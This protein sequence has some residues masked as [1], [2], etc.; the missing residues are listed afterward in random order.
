MSIKELFRNEE[1]TNIASDLSTSDINSELD[2]SNEKYI[3]IYESHKNRV[4]PHTD[5]SDPEAFA[6]YGSAEKYYYDSI[7]RIYN[8]YPYDGSAFEKT[9]WRLSSSYL[10]LHLIDNEYPKTNG[11]ISLATE[12]WGDQ[13]DSVSNYGATSTSSYEY[14]EVANPINKDNKVDVDNGVGFNLN[15]DPI[16]GNTVEFWLKKDGLVSSGKTEREVIFDLWNGASTLNAQYARFRV[17]LDTTVDEADSPFLVTYMSGA[18]GFNS[19]PIGDT[20]SAAKM[21]NGWN[22]LALSFM[23][24]SASSQIKFYVNGELEHTIS[25]SDTLSAVVNTGSVMLLG[26]LVAAP[27]GSAYLDYSDG[28]MKGW[29]KLSGSLDEF[30]FWKRCRNSR[31]ISRNWFTH[32]EGGSNE[33]GNL[34]SL[35][36]Y[37][38]FNEGVTENS[39]I[40]SKI[41][42]YSGKVSNGNWVGYPGPPA[43]STNSAIVEHGA[44]ELEIKDPIIYQEHPSIVKLAEEKRKIGV[45]YDDR[46]NSTIIDSLPSWIIDNDDEGAG[47]LKNITQVI[48]SYFD[49]LQI[50]VREIPR[51]LDASYVSGSSKGEG[52]YKPLPFSDR[53]LEAK[54]FPAPDIFIDAE[55]LDFFKSRGEELVY[56]DNLHDIKNLIYNNIYNN[57]IYIYKSKGT[58]KSFRNLLHCY[59]IDD[60]LIKVNVYSDNETYSLKDT[61]RNSIEK[62]KYVDFFNRDHLDACVI[63]YTSSTIPDAYSYVSNARDIAPLNL[64]SIEKDRFSRKSVTAEIE[65][66]FPKLL[67]QSS[68][69][70]FQVPITS[71]I[72][73]AHA[74]ANSADS[75]PIDYTW[76]T[77]DSGSFQVFAVR[78]NIDSPN[79]RFMLTSSNSTLFTELTSSVFADVYSDQRWHFAVRVKQNK[80]KEG[81]VGRS[82]YL[83][84]SPTDY[85]I[86]FYGVRPIIDNTSESFLV[87]GS[88]TK[89]QGEAFLSSNKRFF[90][91]AHRENF[92]GTV[93]QQAAPRVSSF[94]YWLDYLEDNTLNKHA[95]SPLNYGTDNPI[96]NAYFYEYG[97]RD[98]GAVSPYG[99]SWDRTYAI[100][101]SAVPKS[102][103][104]A[105]NWS[106]DELTGSYSVAEDPFINFEVTDQS[107]GSFPN[108][109]PAGMANY[110][111][112]TLNNH[113]P[114]AGFGFPAN[115]KESIRVQHLQTAKKTLLENISNHDSIEVVD[116]IESDLFSIDER[117]IKYFISLEKSMY[118]NISEEIINMFS[119]M[120]AF[121]NIIGEPVERYRHSY[122]KLEK[123][124][125]IFFEKVHSDIDLD[126]FIDFYKWFDISISKMIAELIP[127]SARASDK[128]YNIVESHI[129]ERNK[130]QTKI[131]TLDYRGNELETTALPSGIIDRTS[132]LEERISRLNREISGYPNSQPTRPSSPQREV[133]NPIW[134]RWYAERN[135][136]S[137][138]AGV[139]LAENREALLKVIKGNRE[140]SRESLVRTTFNIDRQ[141]KVGSNFYSNKNYNFHKGLTTVDKIGIV[142]K[143]SIQRLSD[144]EFYQDLLSKEKMNFNLDTPSGGVSGDTGAPFN[145]FSSSV[146]T[147]YVESSG[148]RALKEDVIVTNHHHDQYNQELSI[149]SP[150]TKAHV[151]GMTHREISINRGADNIDNRPEAWRLNIG[152]N[153]LEIS[154]SLL[155]D[156]KPHLPRSYFY[157]DGVARRPLNIANIKYSTGSYILGNYSNE[158]EIVQTSNRTLNNQWFVKSGSIAGTIKNYSIDSLRAIETSPSLYVGGLSEYKKPERGKTKHVIVERF[159]APG[160]PETMGD[161]NGGHGL[162]V[163][164]AEYSPYNMM[165]Y[166]N[167]NV[168]DFLDRVSR[169][170]TGPA[171]FSAFTGDTGSW[172]SDNPSASYYKINNNP[173]TKIIYDAGGYST[174]AVYDNMFLQTPIPAQDYGY[175]WITASITGSKDVYGHATNPD[176][177]IFYTASGLMYS[178][179]N[180]NI[181]SDS[182]L[183][184]T[185]SSGNS[186]NTFLNNIN[187]VGG[188]TPWKEISGRYHPVRRYQVKNNIFSV[189]R[190]EKIN[191]SDG[192]ASLLEIRYGY[193]EPPLTN[194]YKYLSHEFINSEDPNF[195]IVVDHSYANNKSRF[196]N[197]GLTL[198]LYGEGEDSSEQI[199]D[200]LVSDYTSVN[201]GKDTG[202]KFKN[203][204]YRET[205][206]PKEKNT[207]L[208]KSRTR[209]AFSYNNIWVSGS[210]NGGYYDPQD[211]SYNAFFTETELESFFVNG[212]NSEDAPEYLPWF[213]AHGAFGAHGS[214]RLALWPLA[215]R[216]D[217]LTD[218]PPIS[219][220]AQLPY[221]DAEDHYTGSDN[222]L[223]LEDSGELQSLRVTFSGRSLGQVGGTGFSVSPIYQRRVMLGGFDLTGTCNSGTDKEFMGGDMIWETPVQSGYDPYYPSYELYSETM[224]AQGKDYTVVPEYRFTPLLQSYRPMVEYGDSGWGAKDHELYSEFLT[225]T[226]DNSNLYKSISHAYTITGSESKDSRDRDFISEYLHTDFLKYFDVIN[227]QHDRTVGANSR[228]TS[229][230]YEA[231]TVRLTC[232]AFKRFLPYKGF[233]PAERALEISKIFWNTHKYLISGSTEWSS[234]DIGTTLANARPLAQALFSPGILFNTIKSGI[235]VDYP[236]YTSSLNYGAVH[237]RS[238]DERYG[239]LYI[240]SPDTPHSHHQRVFDLLTSSFDTRV[241]FEAIMDP[242]EYI[243]HKIYDQEVHPLSLVDGNGDFYFN[244]TVS[245]SPLY[246]MAINN[247]LAETMNL[248]LRNQGPSKIIS[249]KVRTVSVDT[250][251]YERYSMDVNLIQ[252]QDFT[253]YNRGSAFG[254]ATARKHQCNDPSLSGY[255]SLNLGLQRT[256]SCYSP[257]TPPYFDSFAGKSES[258]VAI[259]NEPR[260]AIARVVFP[261]EGVTLEDRAYT[262]PEI[263]RSSSISYIRPNEGESYSANSAN[264]SSGGVYASRNYYNQS[265][266]GFADAMQISSS[267]NLTDFITFN[268]TT[269]DEEGGIIN[270]SEQGSEEKPITQWIISPKFECP[271]LNFENSAYTMPTYGHASDYGFVSKGMWHQQGEIPS[272]NSGIFLTITDSNLSEISWPYRAGQALSSVNDAFSQQWAPSQTEKTGSLAKLLDFKSPDTNTNKVKIGEVLS[273]KEFK[274]VYEAVVAIPFVLDSSDNK[275]FFKIDKNQV[276]AIKNGQSYDRGA[277]EEKSYK[278][279]AKIVNCLNKYVFPPQFDFVRTEDIDPFAMF[280]FEFDYKFSGEDLSNM[281][282]NVLPPSSD[283]TFGP[284]VQPNEYEDTVSESVVA[285]PVLYDMF[286]NYSDTEGGDRLRWFV[287]KV[288]QKALVN[289]NDLIRASRLDKRLMDNI[290]KNT[291]NDKTITS[292][293]VSR[294]N[295]MV[296]ATLF[297]PKINESLDVSNSLKGYSYNWPYDYFSFVELIKINAE[298]TYGVEDSGTSNLGYEN[299]RD[300]MPSNA[301]TP[302]TAGVV[303]RPPDPL[304]NR[305]EVANSVLKGDQGVLV[306]DQSKFNF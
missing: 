140:I 167:R 88:L 207:F 108:L 117:P 3:E 36:V 239:P 241:P 89:D 210:L 212:R 248:F 72:F 54:G 273:N 158:S 196:S 264:D 246:K 289:Y 121:N 229:G 301:S 100:T 279:T 137:F 284:G 86:S 111:G 14:I 13:V 252:T 153:Q 31:E 168:R 201:P 67:E 235:A 71:S 30:R 282:Q 150:F 109:A 52:Y 152:A 27:E 40:D 84:A 49:S 107:S 144:V 125:Q 60:E 56:K 127:V 174:G 287:F 185:S 10:D 104:L 145:L 123:L 217:F 288:K 130:Y 225:N 306:P 230:E 129:L 263:I 286:Y 169:Q 151:G 124:R 78:N 103:T 37:F 83:P 105:I 131:P 12:G 17:E 76:S 290:L 79:V 204:I 115:T 200:K 57:L 118:Q 93:L 33:S 4:L 58:E 234:G 183:F 59:G 251:S 203:L 68:K 250:D 300:N 34:T 254:P 219:G 258:G 187:G 114:A 146:S 29:A 133:Q 298:V 194:K 90:V 269:F 299:L 53:K 177:I 70:Y 80:E 243:Q 128:I 155:I 8:T 51:L 281:W 191:L 216:S 110:I 157:R 99:E 189:T 227:D 195:S 75:D 64:T 97:D 116:T 45:E 159:S 199:Y 119:S 182:N 176:Q 247:F 15:I 272:E 218:E 43:R 184:T 5:L 255:V 11:Y 135:N 39:A 94:R 237:S 205:V 283:K 197:K 215:C 44:A 302:R 136:P 226:P 186:L 238:C 172:Y 236:V 77:A 120:E 222:N 291:K 154:S 274:E 1:A 277:D 26:S 81:N 91:G 19:T 122:K 63:Q 198:K 32:V 7:K 18:E 55:I 188:Y 223:N 193:H 249:K 62:K 126:R 296:E 23:S 271:A 267:V 82:A 260:P 69:K 163:F 256:G 179:L 138:G 161:A 261:K 233:Y 65:A 46:N 21:L 178:R 276:N 134:W 220:S 73:G 166:R 132:L 266:P 74:T 165:N 48:A 139:N 293:D 171:G 242:I 102:R 50:Q 244:Q 175:S 253:L 270:T 294:I 20:F 9:T 257:F 303:E 285:H 143:D 106:F 35:G 148:L 85:K 180:T 259:D 232:K 149:Q 305:T 41:L 66:F 164:A 162:D 113:Y 173:R 92:V 292:V 25:S 24:A 47:E 297:D 112:S 211:Y 240:S 22:H 265:G 95:V 28:L 38:K 42:D 101:G 192:N 202:L 278:A 181:V 142:L 208:N 170:H 206:Y 98:F 275:V 61:Y 245:P 304:V 209:N 280:I 228:Q 221:T 224:R 2:S 6:V 141:Y 87:T 231:K 262:I 213:E 16:L 156:T 190:K 160:G 268:N 214:S 295:K 147:G 96:D